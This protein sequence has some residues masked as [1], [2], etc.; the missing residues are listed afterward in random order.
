M[1]WRPRAAA[2]A[3]PPAHLAASPVAASPSS[4]AP[5]RLAP[6]RLRPARVALRGCSPPGRPSAVGRRPWRCGP[7]STARTPASRRAAARRR[8]LGTSCPPPV[9]CDNGQLHA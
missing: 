4:T 9:V 3:Q 8:R 1:A 5:S 7:L 2:P 6:A